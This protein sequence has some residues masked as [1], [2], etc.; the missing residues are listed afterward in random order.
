MRLTF[1]E[2]THTYRYNG[3]PVISVT[4]ALDEGG[5]GS[6]RRFCEPAALAYASELGKATHK[7]VELFERGELDED[8]LDPVVLSRVEAYKRFAL[9]TGFEVGLVETM[10]YD[11]T[12]R[13][14]GRL[15][16]CG[17]LH[18]LVSILDIKSGIV[19]PSVALQL[20][21]YVAA[22]KPGPLMRL[23]SLAKSSLESKGRL[24]SETTWTPM[25]SSR[26][27]LQLRDDGT[28]RLT[29]YPIADFQSDYLTFLS[30]VRIAYDKRK[31]G[32]R[33]RG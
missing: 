22:M 24:T 3:T 7:A 23:A 18:G 27:S 17:K 29:P 14:A 16:L 19:H 28:Y 10:V 8:S 13:Y 25:P 4:Q 32:I 15:D 9:E 30:C 2:K 12:Y 5:Y 26:W 33:W 11:P 31:R 1:D 6:W 20:A 21:G